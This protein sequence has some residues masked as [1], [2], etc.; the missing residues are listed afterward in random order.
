MRWKRYNFLENRDI[1]S[2]SSEDE[3]QRSNE[4]GTVKTEQ[5]RRQQRQ[6]NLN[7]WLKAEGSQKFKRQRKK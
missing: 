5:V 3:S 6:P 4:T 1:K 2:D 7:A